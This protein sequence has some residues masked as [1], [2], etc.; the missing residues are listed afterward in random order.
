MRSG[1]LAL[2]LLCCGLACG[3][4]NGTVDVES[5]S[6]DPSGVSAKKM[7]EDIAESGQLSS[8]VMSIQEELEKLKSTDEAKG[9]ALLDDLTALQAL[10]SP[11]QIKQKAK[12]MADKL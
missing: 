4:G 7:L 9:Q 1:L 12:E 8:D 2:C 6:V 3:C 10:S 11:Q 5:E